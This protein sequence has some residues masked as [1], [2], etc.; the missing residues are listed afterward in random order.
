MTKNDFM[1]ITKTKDFINVL[2]NM[3]YSECA[4][5]GSS[6]R[7]FKKPGSPVLS[8]PSGDLTTGTK[9]M[10]VKLILGVKYYE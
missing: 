5:N 7:I 6:H 4:K 10:L 2:S 9:R 1:K 3:G 8:V